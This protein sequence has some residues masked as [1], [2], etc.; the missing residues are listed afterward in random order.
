M[1]VSPYPSPVPEDHA[2]ES[3][4]PQSVTPRTSDFANA[5]AT[6]PHHGDSPESSPL[7]PTADRYTATSRQRRSLARM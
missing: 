2:P 7:F 3:L 1:S 5:F 6:Q 4:T